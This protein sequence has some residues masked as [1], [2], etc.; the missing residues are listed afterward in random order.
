MLLVASMPQ[1]KILENFG[2]EHHSYKMA[3]HLMAVP[4]YCWK[5]K[6]LEIDSPEANFI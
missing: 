4:S 1:R 6:G 5:E 3:Q 2:A